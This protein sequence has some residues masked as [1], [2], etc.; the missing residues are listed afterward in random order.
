MPGALVVLN[1][2]ASRSIDPTRLAAFFNPLRDRGWSVELR[3]TTGPG[4]ATELAR[5]AAEAGRELVIAAGGDGTVNEVVQ[6]LAHSDTALGVLPLGMVNIWATE[7]GVPRRTAEAV[8][9][10]VSGTVRRVDVGAVD[11]SNGHRRYFLLMAGLGFDAEVVRRT[12]RRLKRALGPFAYVWRALQTAPRYPGAAVDLV[13]PHETLPCHSLMIH[14]GNTRL[15]AGRVQ[16]TPRALADDGQLDL[17][18]L[19]GRGVW[20]IVHYLLSLLGNRALDAKMVLSLRVARVAVR[21]VP[22]LP[23]QVDGEFAGY[24]PVELSVAPLALKA[25]VPCQYRSG[26]FQTLD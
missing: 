23:V 5:L 13:L 1:P 8:A 14:A 10:L 24:S 15:Y 6:G 18:V 25:I 12:D 20:R 4:T 3:P 26:L 21:A 17:R 16:L 19:S 11:W 9:A 7:I 22:A 2:A